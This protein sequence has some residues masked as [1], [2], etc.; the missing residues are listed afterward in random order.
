M[1]AT[2]D[3]S[4]LQRLARTVLVAQSHQ[5]RHLGFSNSNFFSA[6]ICQRQVGHHKVLISLGLHHSVHGLISMFTERRWTRVDT[7]APSLAGNSPLQR[8]SAVSMSL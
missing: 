3:P 1:Q 7:V 5:T 4:S 8:S 6:K 2:S